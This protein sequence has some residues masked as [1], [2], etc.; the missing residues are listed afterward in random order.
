MPRKVVAATALGQ[1]KRIRSKLCYSCAKCGIS[2]SSLVELGVHR[3]EC[4]EIGRHGRLFE[5]Y[6]DGVNDDGVAGWV[7]D[8]SDN[9]NIPFVACNPQPLSATETEI[10]KFLRCI[11]N[12][13]GMSNASAQGVLTYVK[14]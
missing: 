10:C 8:V 9:G 12:G 4:C 13:P 1:N 6:R 14:R 7:E 11:E 5:T 3:N 2:F